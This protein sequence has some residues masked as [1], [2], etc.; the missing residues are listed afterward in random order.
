MQS[1]HFPGSA[2]L[3]G[4]AQSGSRDLPSALVGIRVGIGGET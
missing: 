2:G 3:G 1:L 4:R